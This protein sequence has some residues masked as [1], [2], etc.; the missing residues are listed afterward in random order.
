[1]MALFCFGCGVSLFAAGAAPTLIRA[2][3]RAWLARHVCS[4]LSS[5]RHGDADRGLASARAH[6]RLQWRVRKSRRRACGRHHCAAS[7]A[8]SPGA[9]LFSFPARSASSTGFAYLWVVPT[10]GNQGRAQRKSHPEVRLSRNATFVVF[11]L[12][13]VHRAR[14]RARFQHD[15]GRAAEDGRRA[16]RAGI[17]LIAVGWIATAVFVVGGLAQLAVGRL[18]EY[19]SPHVLFVF[20]TLLL[21]TGV[22]WAL[23]VARADAAGGAV[24]C[25]GRRVRAGDGQRHRARALYG[26]CL[27]RAGLCGALFPGLP[28]GGRAVAAI[29]FLHARGGFDLVLLVTAGICLVFFLAT[30]GLAFMVSGVENRN[31]AAVPAE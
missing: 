18:V 3:R 5:G 10:T 1:M 22:T 14:R 30:L 16:R 4:D 28:V 31:A 26:R 8:F 12:F 27:A 11:G 9:R 13:I 17:S 6:A 2:C 25:D 21:F 29:A 15:H 24:R 23:C 20:V 7:Q 19:F